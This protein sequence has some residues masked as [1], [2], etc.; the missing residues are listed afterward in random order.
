MARVEKMI[1]QLIGR[2]AIKDI[3]CTQDSVLDKIRELHENLPDKP[4][5][6]K[7]APKWAEKKTDGLSGVDSS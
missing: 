2:F 1:K 5:K 7:A 6:G 3:G 4:D